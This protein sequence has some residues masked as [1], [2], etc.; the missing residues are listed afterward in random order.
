MHQV[1]H[2]NLEQKIGWWD[3]WMIK[4]INDVSCGTYNTNSQ[5]KFKT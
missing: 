3:K 4:K 1:N 2:L 5:V